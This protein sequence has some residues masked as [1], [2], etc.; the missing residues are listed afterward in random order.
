MVTKLELSEVNNAVELALAASQLDQATSDN[1]KTNILKQ[2]RAV[3]EADAENEEGEEKEPR[4]KSQYVVLVS[5]PNGV[6]KQDLV[7]WVLTIPEET[8]VQ[9]TKDLLHRAFYDF[10]TT[11][12]GRRLPVV[13]IGEGLENVPG[14]AYK[15]VGIKV[16]T[17]SPVL[18][19]TT[20]N[21]LP[22]EAKA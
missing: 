7:A 5:D 9:T 16:K 11:K 17:K 15:E 4:A 14:T 3:V 1:I 6:I 20:D 22:K 18:V 21:V 12:K 2:L 19:I 8:A 10:N 13:T